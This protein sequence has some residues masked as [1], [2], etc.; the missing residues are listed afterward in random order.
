M[1]NNTINKEEFENIFNNLNKDNQINYLIERPWYLKYI[2]NS[3]YD[4]QLTLI[5]VSGYNIVFIPEPSEDIQMEAVRNF[6]F[7]WTDDHFLSEYIVSQKAVDLYFKLKK[8]RDII[9]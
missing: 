8:A 2:D 9:K 3:L 4:I 6:H 5:K 1:T 7:T